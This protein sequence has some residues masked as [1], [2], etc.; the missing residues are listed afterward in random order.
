MSKTTLKIYYPY[1]ESMLIPI[2]YQLSGTVSPKEIFESMSN[3]FQ[4]Q[5]TDDEANYLQS[6]GYAV[7]SEEY[8]WELLGSHVF[9]EGFVVHEDGFTLNLGS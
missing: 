5:L 1:M 4:H 3:F 6:Q 7:K 8:V 9:F 2:E